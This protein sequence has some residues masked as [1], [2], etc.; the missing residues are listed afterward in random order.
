MKKLLNYKKKYLEIKTDIN[1]LLIQ[2]PLLVK[3][4][5]LQI[6]FKY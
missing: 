6:K 2:M 5:D 4:I 3:R 1:N